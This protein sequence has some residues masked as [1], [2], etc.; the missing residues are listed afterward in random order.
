MNVAVSIRSRQL[1]DALRAYIDRK[2]HSSLGRFG[3]RLHHV[4]VGISDIDS[5]TGTRYYSCRVEAELKPSGGPLVEE[6]SDNDL[7]RAIDRAMDHVGRALWEGVRSSPHRDR[8][9]TRLGRVAAA[10]GQGG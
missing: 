7:F 2:V 9:F 1:R 8:S 6:V 5:G 10:A 4:S 3:D